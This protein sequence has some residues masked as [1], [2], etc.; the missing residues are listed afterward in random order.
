MAQVRQ[1]EESLVEDLFYV[2]Q[3]LD[4]S[5]IK[6]SVPEDRYSLDKASSA[7]IP[8]GYRSLVI[9][10]S[11]LG[12]VYRRCSAHLEEFENLYQKKQLG[13]IDQVN[14]EVSSLNVDR[15]S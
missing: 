10:L 3:G 2:F 4:G 14:A 11:E 9:Q 8:L 6:Y 15:A 13:L 12:W 5:L 1:V 7:E